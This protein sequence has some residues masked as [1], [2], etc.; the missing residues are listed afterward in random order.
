VVPWAGPGRGVHQGDL[1]FFRTS[2]SIQ[3]VVVEGLSK[4]LDGLVHL[5]IPHPGL[6]HLVGVCPVHR[7]LDNELRMSGF[8]S[9]K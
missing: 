5:V 2:C 1:Y 3:V 9:G 8:W 4:K 6:P 7:G